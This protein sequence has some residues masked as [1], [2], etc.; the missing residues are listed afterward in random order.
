MRMPETTS[1]K[2]STPKTG[3][4][5][6]SARPLAGLVFVAPMLLF[7]EIGVL[8]LDHQAIRNAADVWLREALDMLG[9]S[10]YFLLPMLT[11]GLLLAWHH[12]ARQP[13]R[14]NWSVM[15][16]MI[17][18]S[19]V[20]GFLLVLIAGWQ[21][22]LFSAAIPP[23][24]SSAGGVRDFLGLAVGYVGAGIY[25]EVLF[26]LILLSAAYGL[27]RMCG[28]ARRYAVAI[29]VI[30]TSLLFSAAHYQFD[31]TF[32]S[33]NFATNYGD[34]FKWS[35]FF[36]RFMAGVF[37]SLL[38]LFRGFGVAAGSHAMY[39]LFTLLFWVTPGD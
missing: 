15:Y 33:Y 9:F 34:A 8:L 36:F 3:Y 35:S 39:D 25:E 18:E 10:Q 16:G 32:A 28:F 26:R 12:M 5:Y 24:A 2:P 22:S 1:N 38:F 19:L 29:G 13:W 14:V 30:A 21:R 37:F 6:D 17:L 4:W 7:Y 23:C 11:C 27:L 20:F 31:I